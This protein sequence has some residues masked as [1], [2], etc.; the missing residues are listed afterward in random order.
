MTGVVQNCN[1]WNWAMVPLKLCTEK[2]P[3]TYWNPPRKRFRGNFLSL[4]ASLSL[5]KFLADQ[6]DLFSEQE[7][8]CRAGWKHRFYLEDFF[9]LSLATVWG[10]PNCCRGIPAPGVRDFYF[11][12]ESTTENSTLYVH[13]TLNSKQPHFGIIKLFFIHLESQISY[14]FVSFLEIFYL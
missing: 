9:L 13:Q 5:F 10:P 8:N 6:Q 3:G 14:A 1:K 12:L 11:I 7:T 2:W 4:S